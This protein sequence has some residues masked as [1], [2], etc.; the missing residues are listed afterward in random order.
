VVW[1]LVVRETYEGDLPDP[2]HP[3]F[4]PALARAV[5]ATAKHALEHLRGERP[6]D[7]VDVWPCLAAALLTPYVISGFAEVVDADDIQ[8][9]CDLGSVLAEPAASVC[10]GLAEEIRGAA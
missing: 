4:E 10:F 9:L 6:P 7:A 3:D 5:L 1:Q 2:P 8:V